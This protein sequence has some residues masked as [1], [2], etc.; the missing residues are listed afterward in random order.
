[1]LNTFTENKF[2]LLVSGSWEDW[3]VLDTFSR[4]GGKNFRIIKYLVGR[5]KD[6]SEHYL[7]IEKVTE[8]Y[9]QEKLKI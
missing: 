3:V 7:T 8:L 5:L 9:N 1:M 6:E 2:Q 4:G